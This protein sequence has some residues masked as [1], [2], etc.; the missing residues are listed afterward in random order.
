MTIEEDKE[1]FLSRWSRLKQEAKDQPPQKV[2]DQVVDSK[3]PPELP[4]LDKLTPDSDYRAFFHPKVDEDL[5]RAAL[6][7]LFSDPHF[8]VMDGLDVYIDDYSKT[9]PIPPEMMAGL[10]QAQN[11]LRWAKEDEEQRAKEQQALQDV[12]AQ[13]IES[14]VVQSP[15]AVE[16]HPD[17]TDAALAPPD[18]GLKPPGSS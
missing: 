18:G 1:A 4:P 14:P 5:R 15:P 17:I 11:I 2:S 9:E 3:V 12:P 10:R 13:A 6:K 16:S 8:N 7:K